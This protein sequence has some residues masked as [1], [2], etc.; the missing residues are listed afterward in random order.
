VRIQVRFSEEVL[1]H[2]REGGQTF[3]VEQKKKLEGDGVQ[4]EVHPIF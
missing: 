3:R 4:E 2:D 1:G